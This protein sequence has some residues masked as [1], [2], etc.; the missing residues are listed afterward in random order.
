MYAELEVAAR[1]TPLP[2]PKEVL[3]GFHRGSTDWGLVGV[4]DRDG[5]GDGN[6]EGEL[7]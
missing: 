4:V 3:F 2:M 5:D 6:E 1:P 7:V